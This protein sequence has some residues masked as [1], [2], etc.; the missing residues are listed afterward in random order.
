TEHAIAAP[1]QLSEGALEGLKVISMAE[2]YP[3]PFC[4]M[5]LSDMGADVI[6]IERPKGGDPSRFLSAF[7][8]SVNRN[9][10]SIALDIRD[11]NDRDTLLKLVEDSDV[12][13]EGY[14][15][16]KLT[17]QGLSYADLASINP[18]IIYCSITGYGQNGPY[19]DRPAHDLS[20]QG[21]G[22]ALDERLA[23]DVAGSPP[24]LLLGDTSSALYAAIGILSALHARERTGKGTH[25]DI[26]LTDAVLSAMTVFVGMSGQDTSPPP[27]AEPC[28]D[29]FECSDGRSLTLS[30]AHEDPYW[31]AL[32]NDLGLEDVATWDRTRRVNNRAELNLRIANEIRKE[33]FSHW[34]VVFERSNQMWGPA[35]TIAQVPTDP[36]VMARQLV[37]QVTRAD[38]QTQFVVRQPIQFSNYANAPLNRAP[39]LNE[40]QGETF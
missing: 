30:I 4:T 26:S 5:I 23:G 32:C 39:M 14:R 37:Q 10:R 33:P 13:L 28:Y 36:Q 19:K 22:G 20:Y 9:K 15:P 24:S 38:G 18:R 12:F 35:N 1:D 8:E 25:I 2:Q 27:Q 6:Q 7:Y 16:G 11:K 17:K 31:A 29:I 40:H 21:V 3:G 34:E